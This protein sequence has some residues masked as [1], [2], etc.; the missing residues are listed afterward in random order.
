MDPP[1]PVDSQSQLQEALRL[2]GSGRTEQAARLLADLA[3]ARPDDAR[4][5]LL[6]ATVEL[7]RGNLGLGIS[8]LGRLLEIEPA[9][10]VAHYQLGVAFD[11]LGRRQDALRSYERAIE[12][13]PA[14][15]EAHN[16]RALALQSLGRRAEALAGFE[17]ALR[18]R[19]DYANA[20]AN[21]ASVLRDQGRLVEA[22]RACDLALRIQPDHANA[23]CSRG[24]ALRDLHRYDESLACLDRA[25]AIRPDH[26]D[27][28]GHRGDTLRELQRL[29]EAVASYERAVALH[30]DSSAWLGSLLDAKLAACDWQHIDD[31]AGRTISA[32]E[33]GHRVADPFTVMLVT[34]DPAVQ[35]RAAETWTAGLPAAEPPPARPPTPGGRRAIRL[36]YFSSD[37]HYHATLHLMLQMLEQHDRSRFEVLCFSFGPDADHP[38]RQ[39]V[40]ACSDEFHDVRA[41]TDR[42]IAELAR[43]LRI[44]VA[45][46]L[47]GYTKNARAGIFA[48]RCAPIQVSYLGYPGT[49]GAAFIDYVIADHTVVPSELR[50]HFTEKIAYLP[51]CYQPNRRSADVAP[52]SFPRSASGLPENRFVFCC[53]NNNNKITPA[54]FARWMSILRRA[55]ASVLW[56]LESNRG[57]SRNLR[58][59]AHRLGVDPDRLVF[60]P[61]R[62]LEEQLGRIA[63]ADLFLDTLPY[64]AHTTASDALRMGVPVLTEIGRSF[65]GR[66][67]ASLLRTLRLDELIA[68]GPVAYED[69]AVALAGDPARLAAIRRRLAANVDSSPLFDPRSLARQIE[70]LYERMC[71]RQAAGLEPD[72]IDA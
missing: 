35:K 45:V 64:N 2:H 61:F 28:H 29:D 1:R 11:E 48:Q 58:A 24:V 54:T 8:L 16:N 49:M 60:A 52:M 69:L 9:N 62:P 37:L 36:A 15:A 72:H 59:E 34:G 22:L 42:E 17:H 33:S 68:D 14:F 43:R 20:H 12:A 26:A 57:S 25:I 63:H 66:V 19:P 7:H 38:W 65:C 70:A 53:F 39:R 5:L 46:D 41:M 40:R 44:D 27:A 10:A 6:R 21:L 50:R 23:H 30:P 51:A 71:E 4:V 67:A 32:I 3:G 55:E 56:L 18:I 47:K 31:L 13:R